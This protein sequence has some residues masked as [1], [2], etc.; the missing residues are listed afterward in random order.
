[1]PEGER[2]LKVSLSNSIDQRLAVMCFQGRQILSAALAIL[3]GQTGV[4]V[5]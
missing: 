3:H 1:M 2:P 4:D 5:A